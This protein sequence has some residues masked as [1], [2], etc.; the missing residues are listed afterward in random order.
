M[1]ETICCA[2][3]QEDQ[4]IVLRLSFELPYL[5]HMHRKRY[6]VEY[7]TREIMPQIRCQAALASLGKAAGEEGDL[8]GEQRRLIDGN[9]SY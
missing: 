4:D 7:T 9:Q 5:I 8:T 3:Q 1:S 6:L 2:G